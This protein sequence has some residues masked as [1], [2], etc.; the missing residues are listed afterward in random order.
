MSVLQLTSLTCTQNV[1][2]VH[3]LVVFQRMPERNVVSWTAV[4]SGY[5]RQDDA[6]SAFEFFNNMRT[7]GVDANIYTLISMLSVFAKIAKLE[8]GIAVSLV[9]VEEWASFRHCG[10]RGPHKCICKNGNIEL[11]VKRASDDKISMSIFSAMLAGYAQIQVSERS[12]WLFQ[13]ILHQ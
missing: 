6:V 9:D 4:I 1:G 8:T 11:C 10:F 3:A 2:M 5:I 13:Q 12:I 7:F